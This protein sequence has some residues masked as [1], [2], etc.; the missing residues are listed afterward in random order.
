MDCFSRYCAGNSGD[1]SV[2]HCPYY[3]SAVD[4][5]NTTLPGFNALHAAN[6]TQVY[7]KCLPADNYVIIIIVYRRVDTIMIYEYFKCCH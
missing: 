5:D 1:C 6:S 3:A 4:F 2:S 7:C